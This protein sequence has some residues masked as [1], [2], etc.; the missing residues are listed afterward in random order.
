[1]RLGASAS[2][3][4]VLLLRPTNDLP[5]AVGRILAVRAATEPNFIGMGTEMYWSDNLGASL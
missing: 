3:L 5:E 1:L 4:L 2:F